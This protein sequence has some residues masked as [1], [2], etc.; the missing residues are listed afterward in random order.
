LVA[1]GFSQIEG[2]DYTKIF[3]LVIKLGSIRT[4]LSAALMKGWDIRQLDV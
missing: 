2:L 1:K 3:S 4:I